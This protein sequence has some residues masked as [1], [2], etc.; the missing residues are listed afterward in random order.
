M[1]HATCP[2]TFARKRAPVFIRS[3][4]L[5]GRVDERRNPSSDDM[6]ATLT[7]YIRQSQKGIAGA[8]GGGMVKASLSNTDAE[9]RRLRYW[10]TLKAM[11]LKIMKS[12]PAA[13]RQAHIVTGN[14][15]SVSLT[16]SVVGCVDGAKSR[17]AIVERYNRTFAVTCKSIS[18]CH[19]SL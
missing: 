7:P 12:A 2:G 3:Q 5:R 13:L 6:R 11:K 18:Q 14:H 4:Q 8:S 15:R 9:A 17:P 10:S 19:V 16:W 1:L